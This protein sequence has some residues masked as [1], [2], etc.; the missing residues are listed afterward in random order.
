MENFEKSTMQKVCTDLAKTLPAVIYSAILRLQTPE[1]NKAGRLGAK[2]GRL[3]GT[4]TSGI[5]GKLM[6]LRRTKATVTNTVFGWR[7]VAA[8]GA[9]VGGTA[10]IC[11]VGMSLLSAVIGGAATSSSGGS[12]E[13]YLAQAQ[14]YVDDDSI[15]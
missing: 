8:A 7:G 4:N 10:V 2:A 14:R 9:A 3:G 5:R 1:R 13:G 11:L 15:G 6:Q 12:A